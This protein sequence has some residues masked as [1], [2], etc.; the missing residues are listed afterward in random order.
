MR[1]QGPLLLVGG[2]P[3]AAGR[4]GLHATAPAEH[5]TQHGT[6]QLTL[7]LSTFG[8]WGETC[9]AVLHVCC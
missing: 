2:G 4:P 7:P 1:W 3:S 6:A 8:Q 5:S 9:A